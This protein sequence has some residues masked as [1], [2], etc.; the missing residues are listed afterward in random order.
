MPLSSVHRFVIAI[1][2]AI[3]YT[4][5]FAVDTVA[6]VPMTPPTTRNAWQQPFAS[7]SIW[8]M[9]ITSSAT[10]TPANIPTIPRGDEW[11]PMPQIDD[12]LIVLR[13]KSPSTVVH[14]SSAG[15]TGA[16]R[17]N[18]TGAALNALPMPADLVMPNG[19]GNNSAVFMAED[20]R[21]LHHLQ[22]FTR[23]KAGGGAT[24]IGHF[25]AVDLY[26]DGRIG[27]HGAS[28]L[29]AIGG[30]LRVGELRPGG[31]P[32][33]HALKVN[34]DAQVV[35]YQCKIMAD[36]F[37]WPAFGADAYAVGRYG[38]LRANNT[39]AMKMG[40]LLALPVSVNIYAMGME[41]KP[42]LMLAWTLQ[43]YGAYIVDDT[44]GGAFA[45]NA[46]N[47]PDGSFRAQF[48]ADWGVDLEARVNDRSKNPWVRDLQRI[49]AALAV[50][51]NHTAATPGGGGTPRQPLAP[52]L[53]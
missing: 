28:K 20:G 41:T 51:N 12:E 18:A 35:L 16:D 48:K 50:V 52:P 46:E 8:N 43:N 49:V 44:N 9:P 23:C 36:C 5:A 24:A 2:I 32:P 39:P 42:G 21:T 15:W 26:G 1:F 34:V 3:I 14:L 53:R 10:Y 17:C 37:R 4:K 11:A 6:G 30:S 45:I 38:S 7:E 19:N 31:Q 13:P 47:G 25:Q 22:P 27:S 33:R 29:S 40:A